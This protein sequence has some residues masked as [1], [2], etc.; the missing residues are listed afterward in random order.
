[1]KNKI[2]FKLFAIVML[3]LSSLLIK[4]ENCFSS[5]NATCIFKCEEAKTLFSND[6]NAIPLR[7][8]DGFMIKI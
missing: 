1:M 2:L 6:T 8:E 3:C 4:S 7:Y 5:V